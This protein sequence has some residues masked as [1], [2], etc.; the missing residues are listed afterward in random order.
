MKVI[1]FVSDYLKLLLGVLLGVRKTANP[2]GLKWRWKDWKYNYQSR[3]KH[4]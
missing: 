2:L 3:R 1:L 4:R